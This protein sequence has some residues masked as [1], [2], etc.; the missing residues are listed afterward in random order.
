MSITRRLLLKTS[1]A[2]AALVAFAGGFSESGR[3]LVRG[4]WAGERP[5]HAISGNAPKP[6]FR[7]DPTT[8]DIEP[9]PGQIVANVACLGCTTLCGV[10]VRVDT[11]RNRVIRVAGNPYSPLS[12]DPFLPYGTPVRESLRSLSR[13]DEKGLQG[14]STACGRG[15]AALE[16]L[17]SPFRI[18]TPMKRVGPR[19]SGQWE[20]IDFETMVAEIAEGGDLFGEGHVDGL[21]TLR[22]IETP[23]DPAAPEPER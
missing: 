6:E 18:T 7:V 15:N 3:K 16:M 20:P 23:I 4:A 11:E 13:L 1:A 5:D 21:R 9:T 12:T 8:G 22:D 17:T 2:G 14:R 19:G 10:R